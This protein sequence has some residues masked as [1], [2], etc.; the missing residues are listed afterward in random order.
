MSLSKHEPAPGRFIP[1]P[2]EKT[3]QD[4]DAANGFA[5]KD[6][7]RRSVSPYAESHRH[8]SIKSFEKRPLSISFSEGEIFWE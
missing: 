7:G 1:C 4:R 5:V 8:A 3:G 6:D 2:V